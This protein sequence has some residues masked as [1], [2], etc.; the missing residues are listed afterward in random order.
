MI[1]APLPEQTAAGICYSDSVYLDE[2]IVGLIQT[3]M[4]IEI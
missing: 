3:D 1:K 2:T 4:M